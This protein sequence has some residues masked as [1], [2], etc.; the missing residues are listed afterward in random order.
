[1]NAIFEKI[2][3]ISLDKKQAHQIRALFK[4]AFVTGMA[5]EQTMNVSPSVPGFDMTFHLYLAAME[6]EVL[7]TFNSEMK[8]F[9]KGLETEM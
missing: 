2:E 3:E 7:A 6:K 9:E 8:A 1:M 5:F 4:I